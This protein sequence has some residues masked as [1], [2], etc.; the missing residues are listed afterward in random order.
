MGKPQV[1]DYS[2]IAS[3]KIIFYDGHCGLCQTSIQWLLKKDTQRKFLFATQQGS[4]F[5]E[6]IKEN[7][8][9]DAIVYY[10]NGE[11]YEEA[12]ALAYICSELGGLWKGC[13]WLW[14][15]LPRSLSR[16]LYMSFAKK[17]YNIFGAAKSCRLPSEVERKQFLD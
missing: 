13:Y 2:T 5:K 10:D 16:W 4:Y 6:F 14:K 3:A 8:I 9:G 1:D 17:R 12:E 7:P 11:I 15:I